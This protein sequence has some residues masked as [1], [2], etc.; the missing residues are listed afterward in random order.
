[1]DSESITYILRKELEEARESH[2]LAK[3]AFDSVVRNLSTGLPPPDGS[4]N[5]RQAGMQERLALTADMLALGRFSEFIMT[6][7]MP[8]ELRKVES[9]E[10]AR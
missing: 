8:E 7:K 6:G 2:R 1:V 4:L 5:I 9:S 3:E 10:S